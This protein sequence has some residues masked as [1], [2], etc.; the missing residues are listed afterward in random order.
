MSG[1]KDK[2]YDEGIEALKL[3]V[4]V[5]SMPVEPTKEQRAEIKR[6]LTRAAQRLADT[7]GLGLIEVRKKEAKGGSDDRV[8]INIAC[9]RCG[10]EDGKHLTGGPED[11]QNW[12]GS[13]NH[14][15]RTGEP[16]WSMGSGWVPTAT[17]CPKCGKTDALSETKDDHEGHKDERHFCRICGNTW[18]VDARKKSVKTKSVGDEWTPGTQPCPKCGKKEVHYRVIGDHEDVNYWCAACNHS[19]WVDG[20]DS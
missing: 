14:I 20:P 3:A 19:W 1:E 13:C 8:H 12:C 16:P 4:G 2:A 11:G 5:L 17:A 9:P 7:R 10:A 6:I 15:W 18:W